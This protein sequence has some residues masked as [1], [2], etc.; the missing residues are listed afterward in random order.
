MGAAENF[1]LYATVPVDRY[2]QCL[3]NA[4]D[5]E[6]PVRFRDKSAF[7]RPVPRF[8]GGVY[9]FS[10]FFCQESNVNKGDDDVIKAIFAR[11]VS[12]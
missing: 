7:D 3:W 1:L 12:Q 2:P 8:F 9:G 10:D 6:H 5:V 11:P 4:L